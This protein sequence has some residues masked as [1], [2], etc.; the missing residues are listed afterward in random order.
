[1]CPYFG[2]TGPWN[3]TATGR[4]WRTPHRSTLSVRPTNH[5]LIAY[6]G[7]KGRFSDAVAHNLKGS[8]SIIDDQYF[9]V[10]D[11]SSVL[12]NQSQVVYDDITLL[13]PTRSSRCDRAKAGSSF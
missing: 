9:F 4:R 7:L 11:S 2:V 10:N 5:K 13:K 8:Y 3:R 6:A 1:M 12:G